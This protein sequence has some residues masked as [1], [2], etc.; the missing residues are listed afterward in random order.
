M[1][2]RKD[3][4][5]A[6]WHVLRTA[7][8]LAGCEDAV[9]DQLAAASWLEKVPAGTIV[10]TRGHIAEHLIVVAEGAIEVGM[11]NAEGKR[12]V[13][14]WLGRGQLFGLIPV[15]E[16]GPMIHTA[17]TVRPTRLLRMTRATLLQTLQDHPSLALRLIYLVCR[18][19]RAQYE[20]LAAQSL[21]TLPMR[22]MRVLSGQL[23]DYPDGR[24]QAKQADLADVLGVTRQSLNQELRKLE[25]EGLIELGRGHIC[26]LD[27]TA[28]A[29]GAGGVE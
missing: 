25:R 15:L 28:L 14:S 19:A 2:D 4:P 1:G 5:E 22:L 26:V 18:R 27:R 29:R 11:T 7:P 24:I 21:L 10:A 20:A 12:H 9:V 8:W 23:Q 3:L 16:N 13:T 6:A 17:T